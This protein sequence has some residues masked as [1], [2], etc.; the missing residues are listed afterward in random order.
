MQIK[1]IV[2]HK[3]VKQQ[4]QPINVQ[5]QY[6][7]QTLLDLTDP[8]VIILGEGI[9]SVFGKK[10]NR[11]DIGQFKTAQVGNFPGLF[12]SF[13][14][15]ASPDFLQLS[16]DFMDAIISELKKS[17]STAA[18]GGNI[19]CI[20]YS[21]QQVDYIMIV[22]VKD[23]AGI[24]F[25]S[26]MKPEG[27]K[28][29]NLTKLHQGIKINVKRY[30]EFL[31]LRSQQKNTDDINFLFS[32]GRKENAA[33]YFTEASGFDQGKNANQSTRSVYKFV[34]NLFETTPEL[35]SKVGEAR[36]SLTNLFHNKRQNDSP[37]NLDDIKIM[38]HG[39][40]G[41]YLKNQATIH[42]FFDDMVDEMNNGDD[43]IP[44]SFN[45][46]QSEIKK[47]TKVSYK[48]DDVSFDLTAGQIKKNAPNSAYNW[49]VDN[50]ELL[51]RVEVDDKLK[52]ELLDKVL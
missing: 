52:K 11:A 33:Q 39:Q 29:L 49:D 24:T 36:E 34:E 9:L 45:P 27:N 17:S 46:S 13:N 18:T 38:L 44:F 22:M 43:P 26:Q 37:V 23:E 2:A 32:I 42:Q 6:I 25:D 47:R 14:A 16:K 50:N 10:E 19:V 7:S 51:I 31:T 15:S 3:L 41:Q 28:T 1:N 8:Q 30:A 35:K 40:F 20:E 48:S 21:S 5:Q 4:H 12:E